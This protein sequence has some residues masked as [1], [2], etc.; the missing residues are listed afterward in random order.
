MLIKRVSQC[1]ITDRE[2]MQVSFVS[3]VFNE[4]VVFQTCL[5]DLY[6][7]KCAS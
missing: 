2:S 1:F 7:A 5:S 6:V 3:L 4:S